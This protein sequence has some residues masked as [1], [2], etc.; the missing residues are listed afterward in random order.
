MVGNLAFGSFE[1]D[2]ENPI[3]NITNEKDSLGLTLTFFLKD[4][5][6]YKGWVGNAGFVYGEEDNDIDFYDSTATMVTVG[7]LRRF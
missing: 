2:E 5:F 7:M 1:Y 4:P 3:V 6:G